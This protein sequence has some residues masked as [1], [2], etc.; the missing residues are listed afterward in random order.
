MQAI[1]AWQQKQLADTKEKNAALSAELQAANPGMS[2][3]QL[4]HTLE[5]DS[6]YIDPD[7]TYGVGSPMWTGET[8]A[9]G[10]LARVLGGDIQGGMA[11]G[12]A[13]VKQAAGKNDV[14]RAALHGIV[15]A[16][17]AKA[18]GG[19][20]AG[21]SA[22]GITSAVM[23]G[24]LAFAF[25]GKDAKDLTGD[26]RSVVSN[27][28]ALMGGAV[29]LLAG[30]NGAGAISGADAARVE[31]ENNAL[32]LSDNEQEEEHEEHERE[33]G[34][35]HIKILSP[36]PYLDQT[37]DQEGH[38]LAYNPGL[39]GLLGEAE[40]LPSGYSAA[41]NRNITG[42]RGGIYT[43]TGK[44]D[45]S[46]NTIYSNNGEYYIFDGY[47]KT[48]VQSPNASNQIRNNYEQGKAFE[49][50]MYNKYSATQPASAR[51]IT[52]KT[53]NGTNVRGDIITKDEN[54]GI[55]CI[56]CKSSPTAPLTKNQTIGY[57]DLE[58]MVV[59]LSEQA[60]PVLREGQKSHQH[61]LLLSGLRIKRSSH[62]N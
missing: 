44:S 33:I 35:G 8:A 16:A 45:S 17:L 41:G 7:K 54:G 25:Y 38:I 19:N 34:N 5:A 27:L 1:N 28:A 12:A 31:V 42:P 40:P 11:A 50:E 55:A 62:V 6:R 49:N 53:D 10:L 26:E 20:A 47:T 43:S 2:A 37:R 4:Q 13:L 46:G 3:D 15:S 51:E 30:G 58:K 48:S 57:P 59:Q 18:Q 23:A 32:E 22:G 14:A 52:L 24:G 61:K 36:A 29:G 39:G 56:E 21:A 9:V 60:S